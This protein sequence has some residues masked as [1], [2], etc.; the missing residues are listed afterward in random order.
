MTLFFVLLGAWLASGVGPVT[1]E[2]EARVDTTA[3]AFALQPGGSTAEVRP[4]QQPTPTVRIWVDE[5]LDLFYPGDPVRLRFRSD[6]DAYVA[7]V[8]LDPEGNLELIYPASPWD[9]A[10]VRGQR[11]YHLP[12]GLATSRFTLGRSAG[13]GFFYIIASPSPLDLR[14]FQART[15]SWSDAWGL[16]RVVRGDPFWIFEYLAFL[17]APDPRFARH[18]FDV[19]S[20]HVG[21]RH[22]F[23]SFACYDRWSARDPWGHYPYYPSC[24]RLQRLLVTHPYYYD[25][26]RFRGDRRIYLSQLQDLAPRHGFKEGVVGG[27]P[28]LR[29][30][31]PRSQP[32]RALPRGTGVAAPPPVT[33]ERG[34]RETAPPRSTPAR[35]RPTLE[36]RPPPR[37]A[38][39]ADPPRAAP[40][41]EQPTRA[42]PPRESPPRREE[43]RPQSRQRADERPARPAARPTPRARAPDG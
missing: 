17:L 20:Y 4:W 16:G 34:A 25:T 2:R 18:T 13:I 8:H 30:G 42:A 27:A 28:P 22:R 24:D 41:R 37:E 31:D 11:T 40:A 15:G 3:L 29:V 1:T 6:E 21:G 33:Q 38:E 23:P 32:D 35:Q 43:A 19:F 9:N 12:G 10:L 36:R 26:R 5:G 14:F 7:V 39:R